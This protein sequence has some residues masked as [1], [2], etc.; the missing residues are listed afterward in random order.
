MPETWTPQGLAEFAAPLGLRS[1]PLSGSRIKFHSPQSTAALFIID[2]DSRNP[3]YATELHINQNNS[4]TRELQDQMQQRFDTIGTDASETWVRLGLTGCDEFVLQSIR[5][6]ASSNNFPATPAAAHT[7]AIPATVAQPRSS[8]SASAPK[9]SHW[10]KRFLDARGL[11]QPNGEPLYSYKTTDEEYQTIALQLQLAVSLRGDEVLSQ[12]ERFDA[13]FVLFAAEWWRREFQGGAWT[14]EPIFRA[15]DLDDE[16][17][18]RLQS[19]PQGRLYP[20]LQRGFACWQRQIFETDVGRTFIGSLAAEG[21]LPLNLLNSP[22]AGLQHYFKQ[23]LERYL[24]LRSLGVPVMQVAEELASDLPA[25]FRNQTVYRVAGEIVE[26]TLAL[27]TEHRLGDHPDPVAQLDQ[28]EPAWRDRFSLALDNQPA[29]AL[30]RALVVDAAQTPDTGL[31]LSLRRSLMQLPGSGSY[32]LQAR[33]E[34]PKKVSLSALALRFGER[35]N[36]PG[37]AELWLLRPVRTRLAILSRVDADHYRIRADGAVWH[38]DVASCEVTLGLLSYG[39]LLAEAP[40]LAETAM[41]PSLPWVFTSIDGKLDYLGQGALRLGAGE[42]TVAVPTDAQL[43]SDG[44]TPQHMGVLAATGQQLYRASGR[45]TVSCED[46]NFVIRGGAERLDMP[47]Y[48]LTGQRLYHPANVRQVFVGAPRLLRRSPSGQSGFVATH[49]LQWR[50]SG[51][52]SPWQTYSRNMVGVVDLRATEHG[53]LLFRSRIAVLPDGSRFEFSPGRDDRSGSLR[54]H[55]IPGV[56]LS[57]ASEDVAL[58]AGGD[59]ADGTELRISRGDSQR[60]RFVLQLQWPQHPRALE[61]TLPIPLAGARFRGGDGDCLADNAAVTLDDLPGLHALGFN[62][63]GGGPESFELDIDVRA[64]DFDSKTQSKLSSR[65]PL[66]RVGGGTDRISELALIQLRDRFSQLF[67]MS[68]DLDCEIR[69]TLRGRRQYARLR[70][71]RYAYQLEI[72]GDRLAIESTSHG[73]AVDLDLS[74]GLA[75]EL[76][77]LLDP[78]EP[79]RA[80]TDIRSEGVHTG[81]WC[82]PSNLKPGPWLAMPAGHEKTQVRP[83]IVPVEG[84]E[85][86]DKGCLRDAIVLPDKRERDAA[87]AACITRMAVDYSHPDWPLVKQTLVA[88]A[89]LPATTLDLWDGFARHPSAMAMLLVVA[90]QS[91][92]EQVLKLAEELPFNWELV[93]LEGWLAALS[94]VKDYIEHEAPEGMAQ[95]LV[96]SVV[97]QKLGLMT[98]ADVVLQKLVLVLRQRLLGISDSDLIQAR[99]PAAANV[100]PDLIL[101][102]VGKLQGQQSADAMWPLF[103]GQLLSELYRSGP[104]EF[105]RVYPH[106]APYMKAVL[107]APVAMAY[108]ACAMPAQDRLDLKRTDL[109]QLEKIRA[110]APEWYREAFGLT[111]LYLYATNALL[112]DPSHNNGNPA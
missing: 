1:C 100:I 43:A 31:E 108:R 60:S 59:G 97:E 103:D 65:V 96:E 70:L 87:I 44:D 81:Q 45:L 24:P 82:L 71:A 30:L 5:D 47:Q 39:E 2:L 46:G 107:H 68:E 89:H 79:G 19:N 66:S 77:A 56:R 69:L 95:R 7:S 29:Q 55:A 105:Q 98:E 58:E 92:Y 106:G 36:W 42:L 8:A 20:A 104:T 64:R 35:D 51:S 17:I 76:H 94:A 63:A 78:Q 88:F 28:V 54:V 72:D 22:G 33:L 6:W 11:P 84:C 61:L 99:S 73:N 48:S 34:L 112:T 13:L 93:S 83:R 16:Q 3:D 110:F 9:L 37:H 80:L 41:D 50:H 62:L 25:S 75:L 32:R 14:W 49:S 74:E 52:G 101:Q 57:S 67:A 21:G 38:G 10:L 12:N 90:D 40:P 111:V 109:Y 85:P 4:Q 27:R 15:I 23:L 102:E 18:Q 26:T 91:S 53:E 86:S